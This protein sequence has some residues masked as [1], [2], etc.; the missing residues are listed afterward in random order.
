MSII[1]F[2]GDHIRNSYNE[3]SNFKRHKEFEFIFPEFIQRLE[4]PKSIKC[5][6]TEKAIMATKAM[7]MNDL[8]TFNKI[9]NSSIPFEIK[10]LGREVKPWNQKLWDDN[11]EEIAFQIVFQKFSKV[12]DYIDILLNTNDKILVE[13][14]TNDKIWGIGLS[15]TDNNIN[16]IK[17]WKG[18]NILGYALMEARETIKNK[19][20]DRER[21]PRHYD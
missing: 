2:Y 1:G 16:D 4:F 19:S 5:K 6:F 21:I 15:V 14:T 9:I 7:M 10:N 12:P 13:A 3:F 8:E 17:K 11:L 18:K 20:F